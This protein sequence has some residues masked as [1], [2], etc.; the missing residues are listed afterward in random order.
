MTIETMP[1][2]SGTH[3]PQ[4]HIVELPPMC[5][6]S[7]NPRPGSYI[8][9]RY[10]DAG[11]FLEV[12]SLRH[13]IQ[14][15]I[16]GRLR[17]GVLI[18]DMEQTIDSIAHD[19]AHAVGATVHLRARLILDAGR[20]YRSVY[21]QPGGIGTAWPTGGAAPP[22][23]HGASTPGIGGQKP[24]TKPVCV[25]SGCA[26]GTALAQTHKLPS[27]KIVQPPAAICDTASGPPPV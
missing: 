11:L 17:N 5:P 21:A 14:Q 3:G 13:E 20:M 18:R 25:M 8:A 7:G 6:V 19:C 22:I 15:Y 9:V 23:D 12:Y 26:C 1:N 10:T 4:C 27:C 24:P 2:L 16:G